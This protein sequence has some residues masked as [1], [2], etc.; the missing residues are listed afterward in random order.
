MFERFPAF[1]FLT[2]EERDFVRTNFDLDGVLDATIGMPV[3]LDVAPSPERFR[4]KYRSATRSS[5]R[6]AHRCFKGLRSPVPLFFDG[7]ATSGAGIAI[8][9]D[10]QADDDHS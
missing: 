2:P 6:G 1:V 3:E 8:A 10:G 5:V 7:A 4:E 9:L